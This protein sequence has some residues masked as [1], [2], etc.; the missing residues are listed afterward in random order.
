MANNDRIYE[1]YMGSM[2][3]DFK[4]QTRTRIDWILEQVKGKQNILDVGCSQGI[5]SILCAEQGA[6]VTGVEIQ[7]ENVD[8]ANN[9]LQKEYPQLQEKIEFIH[10]DFMK[11]DKQGKYDAIILTEV[12]EHLPNCEEFLKKLSDYLNDDGV[13]VITTPFGYCDH[14]D[15][16]HTFYLSSFV[17]MVSVA[18][19]IKDIHYGGKW[20]GCVAGVQSGN[21]VELDCEFFKAQEDAYFVIHK[22]LSDRVTSL[23]SNLQVSNKKYKDACDNIEKLKEWRASDGK[24]YD[25]LLKKCEDTEE[26]LAIC[27]MD[28]EKYIM[29]FERAKKVIQK[30]QR[31]N[32]LL[33]Q[34]LEQHQRRWNRLESIWIFRIALKEYRRLR[35]IR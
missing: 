25:E 1:A 8:Y 33:R 3:E 6:H 28:N 29:T 18:F 27:A 11:W 19:D 35:G 10:C 5:V 17:E 21:G 4:S 34:E 9:I 23:Y 26:K 31:Q 20:I 15:H 30:Q 16:V 13:I 12:I 14:P 2:G 24:K 22:E 32:I 7:Q